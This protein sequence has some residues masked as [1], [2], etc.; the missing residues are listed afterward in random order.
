MTERSKAM[1]TEATVKMREKKGHEFIDPM[2]P[3]R[4]WI[5]V[6][7]GQRKKVVMAIIT[8]SAINKAGVRMKKRIWA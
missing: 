2:N 8:P 3:P 6:G 5:G 4:T 7:D 1:K